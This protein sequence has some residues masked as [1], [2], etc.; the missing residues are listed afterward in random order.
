MLYYGNNDNSIFFPSTRT[1]IYDDKGNE[2]CTYIISN[3]CYPLLSIYT[4]GVQI[5]LDGKHKVVSASR[6][7]G[8]TVRA[9]IDTNNRMH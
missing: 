9:V 3:E 1:M 8:Y 6:P 5:L 2:I 7:Y 4:Y